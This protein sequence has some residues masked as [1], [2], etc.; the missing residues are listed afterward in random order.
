[1]AE[2]KRNILLAWTLEEAEGLYA[3]LDTIGHQYRSLRPV[4]RALL[5]QIATILQKHPESTVIDAR[6]FAWLQSLPVYEEGE[7][8]G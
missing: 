5:D 7:S 8:D 1:M 3:T 4:Q 2:S 6:D